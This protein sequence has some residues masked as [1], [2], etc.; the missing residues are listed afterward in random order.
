MYMITMKRVQSNNNFHS[1]YLLFGPLS[2]CY[3]T[4][5][6]SVLLQWI[7]STQFRIYM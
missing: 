3:L 7:E 2:M 4:H 6:V 1:I 5:C